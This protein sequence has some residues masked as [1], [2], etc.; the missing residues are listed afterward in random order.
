MVAADVIEE[1]LRRNSKENV[2]ELFQ[3]FDAGNLFQR[4]GIAEDK[5]AETEI[6]RHDTA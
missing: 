3:V 6:I 5:V 4:I 1:W 2:L